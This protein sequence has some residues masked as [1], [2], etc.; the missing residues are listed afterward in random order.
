MKRQA[1]HW[2][3]AVAIIFSA[4]LGW[5]AQRQERTV[6]GLIN[7]GLLHAAEKVLAS[8]PPSTQTE[9]LKARVLVEKGELSKGCRLLESIEPPQGRE[10]ERITFLQLKC[11]LALNRPGAWRKTLELYHQNPKNPLLAQALEMAPPPPG[12]I[13]SSEV[14]RILKGRNTKAARVLKAEA[15]ASQ[16]KEGKALAM[17]ERLSK[18]SQR[19]NSTLKRVLWDKGALLEAQGN[20]K[21]AAEVFHGLSPLSTSPEEKE[22][23]E[24][25]EAMALFREGNSTGALSLIKNMLSANDRPYSA[26]KEA[27]EA[28]V[29]GDRWRA[30]RLLRLALSNELPPKAQREVSSLLA[31]LLSE[32]G[33]L[34]SAVSLLQGAEPLQEENPP[35][36]TQLSPTHHQNIET[37]TKEARL[38]ARIDMAN[39]ARKKLREAMRLRK[40][41]K[42]EKLLMAMRGDDGEREA[43][44]IFLVQHGTLST[45]AESFQQL[46]ELLFEQER[47][48]DMLNLINAYLQAYPDEFPEEV[49]LLATKAHI[50]AENENT[51]EA[52]LKSL[53]AAEVKGAGELMGRLL[54]SKGNLSEA[55]KVLED[56]GESQQ[57]PI[58]TAYLL[59]NVGR[60]KEANKVLKERLKNPCRKLLLKGLWASQ[61]GREREALKL[62]AKAEKI[63]KGGMK[64]WAKAQRLTKEA[65]LG[66]L[67]EA[68]NA[69]EKGDLC[70][71][72]VL[73]QIGTLLSEAQLPL[74][75]RSYAPLVENDPAK[76]FKGETELAKAIS[77]EA[78]GKRGR[79]IN[80]LKSALPRLRGSRFEAQIRAFLAE[81]L[82]KNLR[83]NEA[84]RVTREWPP[85]QMEKTRRLLQAQAMM[86][87]ERP[88]GAVHV[89]QSSMRKE[90]W[91]RESLCQ[92]WLILGDATETMGHPQTSVAWY[93]KWLKARCPNTLS[94]PKLIKLGLLLE[95]FDKDQDAQKLFDAAIE[96]GDQKTKVEARFWLADLLEKKG[97]QGKALTAYL[98]IGY[99]LPPLFPWTITAQYRAAVLLSRDPDTRGDALAIL[100]EIAKN[101]RNDRWGEA[102]LREMRRIKADEDTRPAP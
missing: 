11:R 13:P 65:G 62:A 8:M 94:G 71:T 34:F 39:Q 25:A 41:P 54:A 46:A 98:T 36:K 68:L 19:D 16:G 96:K 14:L 40:S 58:L 56:T 27:F 75:F 22:R 64:S 89:L 45:R 67:Q 80:T 42:L 61:D 5:C 29:E 12:A 77:F 3:V 73:G 84:L 30:E 15:L 57:A 24:A 81:L 50:F 37:L 99:G 78:K 20:H 93:S 49:M 92:G 52:L 70:G 17:I 63:C 95:R 69:A 44:L 87:T 9:L 23:V 7:K 47:Y 2:V 4:T 100:N 101:H 102:A 72:L 88:Q 83:F 32:D 6:L 51:A 28:L 26:L 82:E 90:R 66:K 31:E 74:V 53:I 21:K 35:L 38:L 79:A 76:W 43:T 33:R 55:L 59:K 48:Q 10:G 18:E 1:V 85:G 97:E 91:S 60:E 86:G